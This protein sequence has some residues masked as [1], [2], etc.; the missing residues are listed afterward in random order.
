MVTLLV[1]LIGLTELSSPPPAQASVSI[2]SAALHA[3]RDRAGKALPDR[4][5]LVVT[6]QNRSKKATAVSASPLA[7]TREGGSKLGTC[8]FLRALVWQATPTRKRYSKFPMSLAAGERV[9]VK[10]FYRIATEK[11]AGV[12]S[13][14]RLRLRGSLS[15]GPTSLPLRTR[16]FRPEIFER[17]DI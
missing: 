2:R 11:G 13:S 10:L 4:C 6:L 12:G 3:Y 14:E 17:G 9:V 1:G 8:T 7:A 16:P 15:I 5:L